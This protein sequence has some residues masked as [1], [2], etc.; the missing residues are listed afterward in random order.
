[1]DDQHSLSLTPKQEQLNDQLLDQAL[2]ECA[3]REDVRA[4][5]QQFPPSKVNAA[6]K[7]APLL[8]KTSLL[9]AKEFDGLVIHGA[10]IDG[11]IKD[12]RE[13]DSV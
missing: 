7:R 12:G 13:P 1:M 9:L 5:K 3:T 10:R 4:L 2:A 11:S 6:W 8:V